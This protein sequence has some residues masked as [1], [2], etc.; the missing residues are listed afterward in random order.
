MGC[1][2]PQNRVTMWFLGRTG[3][4]PKPEM[5]SNTAQPCGFWYTG[6]SRC[7]RGMAARAMEGL[8]GQES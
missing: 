8:S 3:F 4:V 2:G 1:M 5:C 7:D 6:I